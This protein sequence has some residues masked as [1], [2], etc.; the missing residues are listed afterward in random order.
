MSTS[1]RI[2]DVEELGMPSMIVRTRDVVTDGADFL[3]LDTDLT[4]DQRTS[5]VRKV[6]DSPEKPVQAPPG[7]ESVGPRSLRIVDIDDLG[8]PA[9]IVN[10]SDAKFLLL[11]QD[12]EHDER[13]SILQRF[14]PEDDG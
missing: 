11:D 13:I 1:L 4:S 7:R 8:M 5:I 2:I 10:T 6:L 12:V 3:L 14:F 9:L